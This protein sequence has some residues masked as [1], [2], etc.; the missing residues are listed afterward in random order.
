[1]RCN[2]GHG[3]HAKLAGTNGEGVWLTKASSCET[4]SAGTNRLIARCVAIVAREEPASPTPLLTR[5]TGG[6][7]SY[8]TNRA[9]RACGT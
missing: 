1:M 4:H 6:A 9:T 2:H 7:V 3:S 8:V 5:P